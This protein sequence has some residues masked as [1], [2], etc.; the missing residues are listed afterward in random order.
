MCGNDKNIKMS[1]KHKNLLK[2]ILALSSC[3]SY[4]YSIFII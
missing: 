3:Y 2:N 1:E 4:T